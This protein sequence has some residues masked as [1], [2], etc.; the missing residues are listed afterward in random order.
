MTPPTRETLASALHAAGF[1]LFRGGP[2]DLTLVGLR[3]TPGTLDRFDDLL[4]CL[5]SDGKADRIECWPATMDPGKP[6]IDKPK[7]PDGTA[8]MAA[9][10]HPQAFTVGTHHPGT[11]GAYP[12]LVPAAP[13]SVVRY[14]SH[15]DYTAGR[16]APSTST[17]TQIHHAG[18]ASTIVGAC[19][20]GCAV[21]A[22]EPDFWRLMDLVAAQKNHG[23]GA[24]FSLTILE[25]PA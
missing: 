8:V 15:A 4:C 3:A 24:R 11:V 6:S 18:K 19:S 13:I 2:Y 22:N 23:H 1:P 10:H 7:R 12:C 21:L 5:Y 20:E 25:W 16:G 17:T 14:K 9:G